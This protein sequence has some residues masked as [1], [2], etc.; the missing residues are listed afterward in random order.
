MRIVIGCLVLLACLTGVAV[1]QHRS[2]ASGGGAV[3]HPGMAG[4]PAAAGQPAVGSHS[5]AAITNNPVLQHLEHNLQSLEQQISA[6]E[7]HLQP[8][9]TVTVPGTGKVSVVQ[10]GDAMEF[11]MG[12]SLAKVQ[13]AA[14]Q[15]APSARQPGNSQPGRFVHHRGE[16]AGPGLEGNARTGV[17]AVNAPGKNV[18]DRSINPFTGKPL[19]TGGAENLK[20]MA[21]PAAANAPGV[22]V[23]M[24]SGGNNP[25]RKISAPAKAIG[26]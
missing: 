5:G 19:P 26:R 12:P 16:H 7:R 18:V 9:G 11:Y 15:T 21:V 1:G 10:P 6:I 13:G 14:G 8:P 17:P 3:V 20:P 23:A 2:A 25:F 4:H 24:G 22:P